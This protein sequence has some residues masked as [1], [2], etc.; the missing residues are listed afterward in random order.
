M[1]ARWSTAISADHGLDGH[2]G[3]SVAYRDE[4]LACV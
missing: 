1:S 2:A 3:L 4:L